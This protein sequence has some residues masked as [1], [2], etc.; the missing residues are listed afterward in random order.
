MLKDL[1]RSKRHLK[2]LNSKKEKLLF[3][4]S[5]MKRELGNSMILKGLIHSNMIKILMILRLKR[6]IIKNSYIKHLL[7]INMIVL[8]VFYHYSFLFFYYQLLLF[9]IYSLLFIIIH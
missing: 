4:V 5:K 1:F 9:I 2:L 6:W 3:R 8:D 7:E